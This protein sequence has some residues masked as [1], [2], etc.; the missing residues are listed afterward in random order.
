MEI[1]ELLG[2]PMPQTKIDAFF[3]EFPW[4]IK[5]TSPQVAKCLYVKRVER[6]ILTQY[7]C[8][9]TEVFLREDF[10]I[11]KEYHHLEATVR[12]LDE[13]GNE[14]L[15]VGRWEVVIPAKVIPAKPARWFHKARPAV[16]VPEKRK[17]RHGS[18]TIQSALKR[19][20]EMSDEK[21]KGFF[22]LSVLPSSCYGSLVTIFKTPKGY[23]LISWIAAEFERERQE[24][25]AQC[26]GIDADLERA[27]QE[28]KAECAGIDADAKKATA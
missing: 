5:Y 20:G 27:R 16:E 11:G 13:S 14:L 26:A 12:F 3:K 10:F 8:T 4:L 18:E 24:I 23:D 17:W 6:S 19:L 28:I 21:N 9:A 15:Q 25:K 1:S 7:P 2:K 22:I